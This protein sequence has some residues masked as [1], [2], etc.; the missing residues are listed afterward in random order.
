MSSGKLRFRFPGEDWEAHDAIIIAANQMHAFEARGESI[1]LVFVE[2]ESNEGQVLQQHCRETGSAS[3]AVDLLA[4]ERT[5]L[6]QAYADT[7]PDSELVA[8]A[9]GM[10]AKLAASTQ[11]ARLLDKRIVRVIE[12]MRERIGG[13]IS[14]AE[15]AEVACLSPDRFR[16]LFIEE[17][18]MRFRPYVLW[19]R[20]E[21]ALAEFAAHK[22]L[23]AASH[24]GGFADSAH[25]SRTFKRMF[26]IAPSSLQLD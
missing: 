17:T 2:P 12:R 9:Q 24:A 18:G 23:T 7:A 15:M 5:R 6:H 26:G 19:L 14:L 8:I 22:S 25:F 10:I 4:R 20:I 13:S 11:M 21:I 16:H 3:I 1:A